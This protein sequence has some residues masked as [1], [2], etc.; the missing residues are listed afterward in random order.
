M[1][2]VSTSLLCFSLKPLKSDRKFRVL[3]VLNST[4]L[5]RLS[6]RPALPRMRVLIQH[7]CVTVRPSPFIVIQRVNWE[8]LTS[9]GY[10]YFKTCVKYLPEK[11]EPLSR[12]HVC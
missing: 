2:V 10:Y 3:Q 8:V 7:Y 1:R 4:P 6:Q 11:P 9:K 12:S 5:Y